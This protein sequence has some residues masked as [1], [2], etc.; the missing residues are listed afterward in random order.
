MSKNNNE[1]KCHFAKKTHKVGIRVPQTVE[2]AL[3]IE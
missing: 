3:K 1:K 2:E